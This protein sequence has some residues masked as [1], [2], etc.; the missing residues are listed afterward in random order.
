MKKRIRWCPVNV[1]LVD[2]FSHLGPRGSLGFNLG[3]CGTERQMKVFQPKPTRFHMPTPIGSEFF[4]TSRGEITIRGWKQKDGHAALYGWINN[5]H[6]KL[7]YLVFSLRTGKGR[8]D[9]RF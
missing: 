1:D 5:N 2:F 6:E 8:I 9:A 7:C 3:L 4:T